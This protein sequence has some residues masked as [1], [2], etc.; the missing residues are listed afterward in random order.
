[1]PEYGFPTA[2]R[3]NQAAEY[4]AVFD[5]ATYK[6]SCRFLLVFAID[7]K[8][9]HPRLGVVVGK[10]NVAKAVQR[11]RVK[12][13]LRT[14]FRLHQDLLGG[15]DIVILARSNLD[16]LSNNSLAEK[17]LTLLN[18]LVSKRTSYKNTLAQ[19]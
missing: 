11:N 2:L 6:V 4:K 10:K 7:N 9:L 12:R 5:D 3:L 17:T 8:L 19:Q 14:S 18:D 15:L 1:M 13:V 16:S